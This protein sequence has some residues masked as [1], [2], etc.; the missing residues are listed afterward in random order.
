MKKF[1]SLA[2]LV[3]AGFSSVASADPLMTY[4]YLDAAYQWTYIDT[5]GVDNANG[6]DSKISYTLVDNFA[7]EGGYAYS[8]NGAQLH[9]NDAFRYGG[10]GWY[11][12]CNGIDFV[13][14]VGGIHTEDNVNDLTNSD[15][16]GVYAGLGV[17]SLITETF[18]GNADVTY[19]RV[20]T[21]NWTYG[22]TGL[23]TVADN[24]AL[25]VGASIT[26]DTN[27]ALLAGVR[28]G[29]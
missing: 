26:N 4:N 2:A 3:V 18:E 12:Y 24:V 1:F 22:V 9:N 25:K 11:T 20:G 14:R 19:D 15:Q 17:R 7:F 29:L 10:A 13:G 6:L 21:G 23:Q 5:E 16:N 28:L 8:D 27:V